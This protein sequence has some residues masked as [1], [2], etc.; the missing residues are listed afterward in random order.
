MICAWS[1]TYDIEYVILRPTNNYGNFQF[2]EKLIPLTV[3]NL[4]RNKKIRLHNNGTPIR[5]WL[6][7]EDTSS[8]IL[9]IIEVFSS[10]P[11]LVKNK[12]FNISGGFEQSNS[13]TIRKIVK[14][15]FEDNSDWKQYIDFSYNRIGQDVRY[16]LNDEKLK[17][18]GWKPEKIFD[19][20]IENI[21]KFYKNRFTF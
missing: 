3:K 10:E 13:D 11:K 12:I 20:E 18:L 2:P 5:N 16:S 6:H 8:A 17:S 15:F 14:S 19:I 7:V 21:V 9:K 4:L 1:R